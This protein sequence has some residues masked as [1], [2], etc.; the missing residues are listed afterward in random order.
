MGYLDNDNQKNMNNILALVKFAALFFGI[1]IVSY[2]ALL[3]KSPILDMKYNEVAAVTFG[4]IIPLMFAIY[5]LWSH[6]YL[7]RKKTRNYRTL[8][9]LENFL[10]IAFFSLL[11]I[12][13]NSYKSEFK[14]IFLF[15]ILSSV[16]ELGSK[17]GIAAAFISSTV[18]LSIDL[19]CAPT[20]AIN[21]YFEN[22]L[23]LAMALILVAWTLGKYVDL[24]KDNLHKK[25]EQ[26]QLLNIKL[27]EQELQ[28]K[29]IEDMIFNNKICYNLLID[30]SN[31]AIFIHRHNK[32]IF[33][34]PF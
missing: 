7:N 15:V 34:I 17:F 31:N 14:Y 18:I 8:L 26:L 5:I 23:I 16:I 27:T 1:V 6:L 12:L 24:Q 21:T 29:Y 32:L 9:I 25:N 10:F 22:D 19:I 11:I 28:R 4:L 30:N 13:S 33:S 20:A 2:G 3:K